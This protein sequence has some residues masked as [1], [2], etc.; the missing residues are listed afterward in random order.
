MDHTCKKCQHKDGELN[1]L[2]T[3]A[4]GLRATIKRMEAEKMA[5]DAHVLSQYATYD[6]NLANLRRE[7]ATKMAIQAEGMLK[8]T[9]AIPPT[10]G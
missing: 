5:S 4:N 7:V 1:A 10:P 2:R 8:A 6:Q 3:A 9:V